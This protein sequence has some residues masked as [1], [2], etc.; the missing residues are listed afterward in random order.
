ME[1]VAALGGTLQSGSGWQHGWR[2]L[3]VLAVCLAGCAT[4]PRASRALTPPDLSG[5]RTALAAARAAGAE[6]DLPEII[7]RAQGHLNEAE[8][9]LAEG[10]EPNIERAGWLAR[11]SESEAAT[12]AVIMERLRSEH[13]QHDDRIQQL[14]QKA[15]RASVERHAL[16]ARIEMLV[17]DLDLTETEIIR[18]KARLKGL[19]S[20][21]EASSAIAEA[22]ILVRRVGAEHRPGGT[23]PRCRELIQ[24]AESQF[25][26]ENYGAAI[27]FALKAQELLGPRPGR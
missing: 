17:R 2:L 19:A 3:F 13:R 22:T 10:G 1:P 25:Q 6:D 11:L 15:D 16:E 7:T 18:T 14:S 5:A 21:A 12:A 23:M 27:F 24:R 4:G 9:A 8:A 26:Q 20:R